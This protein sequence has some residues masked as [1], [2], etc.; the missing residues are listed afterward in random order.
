MDQIEK[1]GKKLD[2]GKIGMIE[3]NGNKTKNQQNW[4][5]KKI[6]KKLENGHKIKK[7]LKNWQQKI[8]IP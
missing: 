2:I 7:K 6:G 1:M 4:K 3:K 8:E 5:E